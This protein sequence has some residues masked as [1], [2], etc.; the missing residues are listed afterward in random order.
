MSNTM[1]RIPIISNTKCRVLIMFKNFQ[2][3]HANLNA[4]KVAVYSSSTQL[5]VTIQAVNQIQLT[6]HSTRKQQCTG[7][8]KH[9][10]YKINFP[11]LCNFYS[12]QNTIENILMGCPRISK[13]HTCNDSNTKHGMTIKSYISECTRPSNWNCKGGVNLSR[14]KHI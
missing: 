9:R 12:H 5:T 3:M 4:Q 13:L 2:L 8:N 14:G 10:C 7:S 6:R 1:H 11:T